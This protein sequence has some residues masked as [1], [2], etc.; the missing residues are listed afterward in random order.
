MAKNKK[1]K[2]K[3]TYNKSIKKFSFKNP[4]L[5]AVIVLVVA[6][7]VFL[8]IRS[9]AATVV[10]AIEGEALTGSGT[11]VS[12]SLA[13]GMKALKLTSST[14][15]SGTVNVTAN[16]NWI[17]VRAKGI[18][19]GTAPNMVVNVDGKDVMTAPIV[20]T[21]WG[22]YGQS[23]NIAPGTHTISV[24][25]TNPRTKSGR[26]TCVRS[27]FIDSIQFQDNT[28][29][30]PP[31]P[32]ADTTAPSVVINSP[33]SGSINKGTVTISATASD[34][35]GSGVSKLEYY[36]DSSTTPF[37]TTTATVSGTT[38][39][40][41]ATWDTTTANN[42]PHTLYAKAYDNAGN[43]QNSAVVS[44]S[45]NNSVT[46]GEI[47]GDHMGVTNRY[48]S[49]VSV[50]RAVNLGVTWIRMSVEQGEAFD[51]N[52]INYAHSK[53][54]KILQSCQKPATSIP[55]A[56]WG[57]NATHKYD[58][59]TT[60][61]SNFATYCAGWVDKG[62][63]AIEIGNEWNHFP[64]FDSD[65][66]THM[67]DST[68]TLQ[69]AYTNATTNAIRAKSSTITILNSGW[70]SESGLL[71]QRTATTSILTKPDTS[72]KSKATGLANHPY[73]YD[74][75]VY[76]GPWA[77]WKTEG[78]YGNARDNGFDKP[79]WLTEIG[80]PSALSRTLTSCG[81]IVINFTPATQ[82]QLYKDYIAGIKL[83]RG[84]TG[85][86]QFNGLCGSTKLDLT[87]AV[88]IKMIMWSTLNDGASD[89]SI[90]GGIE[91]HFGLYDI[92]GNI[93][94]AGLVVKNQSTQL[95]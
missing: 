8:I 81:G 91:E 83:L 42:A 55:T 39:K 56:I 60:D 58:G 67:P 85:T 4:L 77:F 41:A 36:L 38:D 32:P 10:G 61:V 87:K 90:K 11:V 52:V 72:F 3:K 82:E 20:G 40:Y 31:P 53:G 43:S 75:G 13:G 5:I 16:G 35:T 2:M 33:V 37:S 29:A 70:S 34:G 18:Q 45:V 68:F 76:G 47:W 7:G 66:T 48:P 15:A 59:S 25:M 26:S 30:P 17:E 95:W 65:P 51:T 69:A 9:F 89:A 92:N 86:V 23:F 74:T 28:P 84:G 88:P 24:R 63:D 49:T 21:T 46:A 71:D 12:D 64:F 14:A 73:Q 80:G 1:S 27:L 19:C 6:V 54:I 78:V 44:L 94:P 50:D 22:P 57:Q 62:V 79:V 93:K